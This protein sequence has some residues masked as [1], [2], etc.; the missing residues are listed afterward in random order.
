MTVVLV[1]CV[2]TVVLV[3][4]VVVDVL[5][6][7]LVFVVGIT[8]SFELCS[9]EFCSFELRGGGATTLHKSWTKVNKM[10]KYEV[11]LCLRLILCIYLCNFVYRFFIDI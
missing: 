7:V 1:V 5:V 3:V 11:F 4:R 10:N 8:T 9:F 6:V 2:V